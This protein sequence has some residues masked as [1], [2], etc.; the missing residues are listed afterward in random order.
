M[1]ARPITA[2]FL[3]FAAAFFAVTSPFGNVAIVLSVTADRDEAARMQI[4]LATAAAVLVTLLVAAGLGQ[5]ILA[6]FGISIGSFRIAGGLI[7]LPIGL[8]MLHAQP[9]AVHH[10]AQEE[11]PRTVPRSF[12]W[13]LRSSPAPARWPP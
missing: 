6:L 11:A 5:Q 3:K 4:A 10:S 2:E 9:S 1:E 8:S 13:R 7:I 12:R